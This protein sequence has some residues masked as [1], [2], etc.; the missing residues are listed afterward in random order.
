MIRIAADGDGRA[1]ADVGQHPAGV[2]TIVRTHPA[3]GRQLHA[4]ILP[5]A[6]SLT[7][8]V[9]VRTLAHGTLVP[10]P[11]Q[12][13][14]A[15]T[16]SRR[17]FLAA[18]AAGVALGAVTQSRSLAAE[19]SDFGWLNVGAQSYS[20]RK[21]GFERALKQ[22]QT[23]GLKYAEFTRDHV[24]LKS[25]P[26]QIDILKKQCVEYGITPVA[27]GVQSYKKGSPDN[28][29]NFELGKQLG[30]KYLSADPDPDSFD[31][32]DKL[33]EEYKIAIGIHP[34][35]PASDKGGKLHRWYSAEVILPAV[36][37]HHPLIGTCI[38]TGHILRCSVVGKK[39][40][41]AEQIRIMGARNFGLHVK[42]F[43]P[44]KKHEV[45][46]GRGAL[47]L[48]AIV[49]ALKDVGF[50]GY[51][52]LEYELNPEDPTADMAEGLKALAAAV[53]K[54]G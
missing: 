54:A 21:F 45:I 47:D 9:A 19:S 49:K 51:A 42:D 48:V 50:R 34:H 30:L 20:F 11:H 5:A 35:G 10:P 25:T 4:G 38:D 31:D 1:V 15:M 27:Y 26:D 46:V 32:L 2:R 36:K 53:K 44:E 37:D 52:N 39:L 29:K 40:D 23:L 12:G 13:P 41:P 6:A 16:L 8:L 22:Y 3:D 28:R 14:H 43:D 33:C 17:Q 18:S 24:P 7:G